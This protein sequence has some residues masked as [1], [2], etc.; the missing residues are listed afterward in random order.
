ME[1]FDFVTTVN[2]QQVVVDKVTKADAQKEA[3]KFTAYAEAIANAD[4]GNS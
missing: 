2:G 3:E 1:K 4:N